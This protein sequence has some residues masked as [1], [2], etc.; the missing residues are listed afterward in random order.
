VVVY[1]TRHAQPASGDAFDGDSQHRPLSDLGRRQARAL[2]ERLDTL[3]FSGTVCASPFVR[4]LETA[5]LICGETETTFRPAAALAERG[6]G[7]SDGFEGLDHDGIR[8][9]YDRCADGGDLPYPWWPE[10]TEDGDDL[11]ER[12]G[13]FLDRTL[14]DADG[15][16]LL[17][18]HGAT[19]GAAVAHLCGR[20]V[21][22]ELTGSAGF[23]LH[24]N[25][26]LTAIETG[27]SARI[28]QGNDT[29]H[30]DPGEITSN[31]Q[32]VR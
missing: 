20:G 16:I 32:V 4:C 8:S 9:R 15:D 17:V 5:D 10:T 27:D 25:A 21:E 6:G 30:L 12:V 7:W 11:R 29:I 23:S 18:G 2:G 3:G 26:T 28:R 13:A 19:T 22:S 24:Y 14:P 1:I 31:S